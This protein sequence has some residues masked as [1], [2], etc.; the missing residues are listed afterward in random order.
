M[1]VD[2]VREFL[3]TT[4]RVDNADALDPDT[5]LIQR[6][7]IDSID[8]LQL[9]EFLE[10]RFNIS[11]DETE[12]LPSNLRSLAQIERFVARKQAAAKGPRA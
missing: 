7:V 2:A 10:R 3:A 9:V 12:I 5:P 6:G 8:L 11:I 4:L 1:I